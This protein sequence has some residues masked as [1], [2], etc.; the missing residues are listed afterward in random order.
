ML[1]ECV[2]GSTCAREC[3]TLHV[4][5]VCD[6][7]CVSCVVHVYVSVVVHVLCGSTCTRKCVTVYVYVSVSTCVP[8]VW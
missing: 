5:R 8:C 1:R 2:C 3:V 7:T 4:Y 6:S